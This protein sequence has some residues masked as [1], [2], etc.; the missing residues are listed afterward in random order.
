MVT[1]MVD[2]PT[3]EALQKQVQELEQARAERERSIRK[4]DHQ[5]SWMRA[6]SSSR[7]RFP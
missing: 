3:Y 4:F 2:N 6:F 1:I 5:G 7:N